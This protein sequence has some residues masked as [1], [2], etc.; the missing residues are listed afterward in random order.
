MSKHKEARASEIE[1]LVRRAATSS[2]V[3]TLGGGL[4]AESQF[5][6]SAL[7]AS[8]LRVVTRHN[9]SALQYGWAEGLAPLREWI[10]RRLRARGASVSADDVIVTNGAQQAIAIAADLLVRPG[11]AIAV[12][13]ETYPAALDLFRARRL[14][15]VSL[16]HGRASYV[17]PLV[18]NPGGRPLS[19][20]ARAAVARG[21]SP[22]IEDDAYGELRFISKAPPLFLAERRSRTFYVGTLSKT[23]CPGLRVGWLIPPAS[24]RKGAL[25]LKASGDLQAN[26]LTQAV[27]EDYLARTDYDERLSQLRRFYGARAE[28]LAAA[29]HRWLPGWRFQYPEGG[30]S[31]WLTTDAHVDEARFLK[32]AI[33]EGVSFDVGSMFEAQP[34]TANTDQPTRLRLCFSFVRA[35]DLAT[36]VRRLA[37]AWN[38]VA[39][40]ARSKRRRP[41]GRRGEQG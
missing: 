39:R 9:P 1:R 3:I 40:S 28:R 13:P 16:G 10:A 33:A 24:R 20:E 6:R 32:A 27:A 2:G 36:G 4:P 5:P 21:S 35:Q 34:S 12:E 31:L 30:F 38:R 19:S 25:R 41:E 23:L 17:L 11:Q 18:G 26:S 15:V 7:A 22:I 29:V 37:T 8:F 14:K